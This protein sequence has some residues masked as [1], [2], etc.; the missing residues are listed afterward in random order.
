VGVARRLALHSVRPIRMIYD[1]VCRRSDPAGAFSRS[2]SLRTAQ[3]GMD[4]SR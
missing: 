2:A 1:A 3:F 4:D